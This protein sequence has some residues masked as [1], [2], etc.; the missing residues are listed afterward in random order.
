[1]QRFD[2]FHNDVAVKAEPD[3]KGEEANIKPALITPAVPQTNGT[4]SHAPIEKKSETTTVSPAKRKASSSEADLL[5]ISNGVT[6]SPKKKPK[7]TIISS[8]R[9]AKSLDMD[10]DAAFAAK[11]Q[12]EENNRARPTRGGGSKPTKKAPVKKKTKKKKTS[13]NVKAEDD[14]DIEG[15]EDAEKERKVNRNTGFHVSHLSARTLNPRPTARSSMRQRIVRQYLTDYFTA[16]TIFTIDD[17]RTISNAF[18]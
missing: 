6:P 11:L 2:K 13:E 12:A 5:S 14:S 1:M 18:L 4:S 10:H 16:S 7:P 17:N 8:Q 3:V 15:T 9:P